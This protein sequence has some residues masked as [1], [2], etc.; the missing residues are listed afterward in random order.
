MYV[1]KERGLRMINSMSEALASNDPEAM[2][3]LEQQVNYS[4]KQHKQS[5]TVVQPSFRQCTLKQSISFQGIAQQSQD[6]VSVTLRPAPTNTGIIFRRI[7][8]EPVCII[9][10]TIQSL[11]ADTLQINFMKQ[12][13]YV[14][15]VEHLLSTFSGLGIDNAY[16]DI[17]GEELPMLDGSACKFAF[18]IEAAGI[19][20]QSALKHFIR[21][22]DTVKLSEGDASACIEPYEGFKVSC[23]IDDTNLILKEYQITL[24]SRAYIKEIVRARHHAVDLERRDFRYQDEVLRHL[25]LDLIG[26]LYTLSFQIIGS[27]KIEQTGTVLNYR[28]INRLLQQSHAWEYVTFQHGRYSTQYAHPM[29]SSA[30]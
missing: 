14:K 1:E 18:L 19:F 9:P 16:V 10:A 5:N 29:M 6:F 27:V 7:D 22:K 13:I 26:H 28:L 17:A 11:T 25:V 24:S 3:A 12:G 2:Q 4:K 23:A 15:G 20:T 8:L 21:I 30:I